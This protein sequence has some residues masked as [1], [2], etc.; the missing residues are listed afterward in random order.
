MPYTLTLR[1]LLAAIARTT[2]ML[3]AGCSSNEARSSSSAPASTQ[4]STA[5]TTAPA[6]TPG[7]APTTTV[8]VA[9]TEPEPVATIPIPT[10]DAAAAIT[11]TLEDTWAILTGPDQVREWFHLEH[12]TGD[13][14]PG[15]DLVFHWAEHGTHY[16]RVEALEPPSR[17]AFRWTLVSGQPIREGNSTLVEFTLETE[18]RGTR[19]RV[20]ESGFASLD[21]GDEA[22]RMHIEQNTGGWT[23]TF[24]GIARYVSSRAAV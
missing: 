20:L 23:G 3:L 11:R 12:I 2:A 14:R 13:M 8:P 16:A 1:A 21:G 4:T 7:P 24:E 6:T 18:G 19:L 17:F 15:G 10:D 9:T 22:Q 5:P